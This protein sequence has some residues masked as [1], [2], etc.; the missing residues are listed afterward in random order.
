M[1]LDYTDI[2]LNDRL[3]N[4]NGLAARLGTL[5]I[6]DLEAR[7]AFSP[8]VLNYTRFRPDSQAYQA[9]V[10]VGGNPATFRDIQDAIDHVD[11]LGGGRIF[12]SAGTYV[13][14]GTTVLRSN[15]SVFGEDND[16]TVI[17]F[18]N[19]TSYFSAIGTTNARLRNIH[20]N[21]L[22]FKNS[23]RSDE[24][25]I[26]FQYVDDVSVTNCK[27]NNNYSVTEGNG[28]DIAFYDSTTCI[29]ESC[30]LG[31][32]G[33]GIRVNACNTVSIRNN[34]IKNSV[35]YGM[36]LTD[37]TTI[38]VDGNTVERPTNASVYIDGNNTIVTNNQFILGTS[39]MVYITN[40]VSRNIIS[41]NIIQTNGTAV[42]GIHSAADNDN[43]LISNN[44]ISGTPNI[45]I[46]LDDGDNNIIQGNRIIDST[47]GI[48]IDNTCDRTIVIGNQLT[49]CGTTLTDNGTNGTVVGNITA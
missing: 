5:S 11:A 10:S 15:I 31:T 2:G 34:Y 18:N 8:G 4:I 43:T 22:Q 39:T 20:F 48:L 29:V 13:V 23:A 12:V 41:N 24:G 1:A 40:A 7:D 38:L 32:S 33:A 28:G 27:F 35:S 19:G 14:S 45:G 42:R 21:N 47:T 9:V 37:G 3:Q 6:I 26:T 46:W 49:G 30:F 36:I 17:N 44:I 16:N 25:A